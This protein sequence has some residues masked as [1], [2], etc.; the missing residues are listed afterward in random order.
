MNYFIFIRTISFELFLCSFELFF[1]NINYFYVYLK[2][3]CLKLL[4]NY[5]FVHLNYFY[6]IFLWN[7]FSHLN[8]F[9]LIWTISFAEHICFFFI[10]TIFFSFFFHIK[11][12]LNSFQRELFKWE[13]TLKWRT[14][15]HFMSSLFNNL[16]ELILKTYPPPKYI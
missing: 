11:Y 6:V 2:H 13:S 7:I 12:I 8:Y 3:F 4:S 1:V 5:F 9:L 16:K 14:F 10:W 15:L